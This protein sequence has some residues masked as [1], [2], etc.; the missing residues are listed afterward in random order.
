MCCAGRAAV[1]GGRAACEGVLQQRLRL[2]PPKRLE[3]DRLHSPVAATPVPAAAR[4]SRANT[5]T[6]PVAE[7]GT[8]WRAEH[9][10][11]RIAYSCADGAVCIAECFSKQSALSNAQRDAVRCAERRPERG[12]E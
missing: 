3:L 12:P 2:Q 9:L 5:S 1:H 6:N 10:A 7:L 8:K 11:E 4:N